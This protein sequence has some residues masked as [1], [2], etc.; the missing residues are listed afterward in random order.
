MITAMDKECSAPG[1]HVDFSKNG[2]ATE[3]NG[4]IIAD[5]LGGIL[6]GAKYKSLDKIFSFQ[7]GF[8]YGCAGHMRGAPFDKSTGALFRI[9]LVYES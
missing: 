1:L 2:T 3:L 5:V 9:V 6:K 4:L 8:I 7:A